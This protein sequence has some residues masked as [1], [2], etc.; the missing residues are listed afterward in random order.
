MT[1]WY[2]AP[3]SEA[4]SKNTTPSR[5]NQTIPSGAVILDTALLCGVVYFNLL[6]KKLKRSVTLVLG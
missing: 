4:V 3:Q 6:N 2:T 5:R 1:V